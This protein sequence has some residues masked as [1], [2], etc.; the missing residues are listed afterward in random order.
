MLRPNGMGR[1]NPCGR[2]SS[3]VN[4]VEIGKPARSLRGGVMEE[5]ITN[6]LKGLE[7]IHEGKLAPHGLKGHSLGAE[8]EHGFFRVEE[9]DV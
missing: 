7:L 1:V 3:T 2:G 6:A 9:W 8:A 5:A 4:T